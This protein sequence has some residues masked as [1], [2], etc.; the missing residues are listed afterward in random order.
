M[1]CLVTVVVASVGC[2]RLTH[3]AD[4]VT[5]RSGRYEIYEVLDWEIRCPDVPDTVPADSYAYDGVFRDSEWVEDGDT[6][7]ISY[8]GIDEF[9]MYVLSR[10]SG[11]GVTV[12]FTCRSPN[13]QGDIV[14]DE[15]QLSADQLDT[16]PTDNPTWTLSAEATSDEEFL[17]SYWYYPM[18]TDDCLQYQKFKTKWFMPYD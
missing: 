12:D 5:M 11:S 2:G 7:L 18:S 17:A 15:Y 6:V 16:H 3:T 4:L 1:R 13:S 10:L 9:H 8:K 14:C